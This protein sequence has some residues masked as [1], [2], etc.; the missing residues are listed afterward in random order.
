MDVE[1]RA[2]AAGRAEAE[3]LLAD[4]RAPREARVARVNQSEEVRLAVGHLER[5]LKQR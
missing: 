4:V 5:A 3:K 2:R 1:V